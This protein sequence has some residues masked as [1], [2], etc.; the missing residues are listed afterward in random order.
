MKKWKVKGRERGFRGEGSVERR[1]NGKYRGVFPNGLDPDTGNR[2]KIYRTFETE[3]EAEIWLETMPTNAKKS[4]GVNL[5]T[6]QR[7]TLAAWLEHWLTGLRA[8]V[9]AGEL[10]THTLRPY[11]QHVKNTL[12][13]YLGKVLL[14]DLHWRVI[15][16]GLARMRTGDQDR[17]LEAVSA[18]M[19]TKARTTLGVALQAA[20]DDG[21]LTENPAHGL[22]KRRRNQGK[23]KA[24]EAS[25]QTQRVQVFDQDQTRRFLEF[26][27]ADRQYALWALWLDTGAREGELFALH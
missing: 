3:R 20:V 6:M 16:E 4:R 14:P 11:E 18:K 26:A 23:K 22:R 13:P 12:T 7:M 21:L 24:G 1:S 15:K 5:Q 25:H 17:G 2:V 10:A 8:E 19:M 27:K 9:A